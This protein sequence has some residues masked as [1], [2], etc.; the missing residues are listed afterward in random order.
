MRV[1]RTQTKIY[2]QSFT[3]SSC[4]STLGSLGTRGRKHKLLPSHKREIRWETH[5]LLLKNILVL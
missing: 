2:A 5:K 4:L 3:S 1:I